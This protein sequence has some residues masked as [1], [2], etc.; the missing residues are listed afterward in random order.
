MFYMTH[1][2]TLSQEFYQK[3]NPLNLQSEFLV[4]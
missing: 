1:M 2:G 3:S 4:A